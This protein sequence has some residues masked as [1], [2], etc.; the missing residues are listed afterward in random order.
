[1]YNLSGSVVNLF[2]LEDEVKKILDASRDNLVV[3]DLSRLA[4]GTGVTM[5]KGS[6]QDITTDGLALQFKMPDGSIALDAKAAKSALTQANSDKVTLMLHNVEHAGLTAAQK[7]AVKP[8]DL[9]YSISLA[10]GAQAIRNFDGTVTVSLPYD[11]PVPVTVWYLDSAG[12]LEKMLYSYNATTKMLTFNTDHLSLFV[13]GLE[14]DGAT[15]IRL[16]IGALAYT[17]GGEAKTMDAAPEI[18]DGRTMVPLRFIAEALGASVGWDG[19]SQTATVGLGSL[20]LAVTI[21]EAAPGMD[22]P[23]M[24][25]N[26]RTMVPLRYISEALGC[27]VVWNPDTQTIDIAK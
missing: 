21:G 17:V 6:L 2:L 10:A 24:I 20:T 11:G 14:S 25:I 22:V 9:V 13:V 3:F 4:N 18:V 27:E 16:T 15:R 19:D 12:N 1:M 26:D 5:P 8:G 7:A 23:A